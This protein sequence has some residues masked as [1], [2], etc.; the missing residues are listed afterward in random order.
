MTVNTSKH[1]EI[2]LERLL[3]ARDERFR[4]QTNL[5][6]ANPEA[7]L[8]VLTVVM[9]G[10]FK[11]TDETIIIAREACMAIKSA[12]ADDIKYFECRDLPTGYE[13]YI[14]ADIPREEAKLRMCGIEENHPLGRLFDIDVFDKDGTPMSRANSGRELRRCLLCDKEARVCMREHNHS[15]EELIAHIR[16]MISDYESRI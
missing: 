12:L 15:Y 10:K 5:R 3:A 13:T 16:K 6:L 11:R 2:S 14:L 4:I 8:I 9:P 7:T 1:E